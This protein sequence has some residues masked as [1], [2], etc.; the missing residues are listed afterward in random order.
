MLEVL[1]IVLLTV[2]GLGSALIFLGTVMS[3]DDDTGGFALLLFMLFWPFLFVG[4]WVIGTLKEQGII[5]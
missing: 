5:K 1:F 2:W 3:P 4:G